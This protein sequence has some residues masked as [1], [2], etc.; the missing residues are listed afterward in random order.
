MNLS[1]EVN[2]ALLFSTFIELF[3]KFIETLAETSSRDV[4]PALLL[5]QFSFFMMQRSYQFYLF[6]CIVTSVT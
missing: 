3:E 1:V 4:F 5:H 6:Y 2:I